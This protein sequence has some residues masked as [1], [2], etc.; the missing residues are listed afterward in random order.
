MIL[1][2]DLGNTRC[3]WRLRDSETCVMRG[4]L[5]ISQSFDELNV[6]LQHYNHKVARVWVA[7]VVGDAL[8]QAFT[9][10]SITFLSVAPEF[11]RSKESLGGLVNAYTEPGRLGV[12]RWL[13]MIACHHRV[14]GAFLLVSLG[15]AITIDI[16]LEN[17]QHAGGFIAPGVSLMLNSLAQGT[18]QVKP[19]LNE[20]SFNLSPGVSTN[21]AI[22]AALAAMLLGLIDNGLSQLRNRAPGAAFDIIFSGGDAHVLEQF[23]PQAHYVPELVLD[24]LAYVFQ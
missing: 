24:G 17:G 18:R 2:F 8:E 10:W 16:V 21:D 9:Q 6:A 13:G 7:S 12:D 19:S 1:E 20:M 23:Y 3:K 4:S 22:S 5:L 15:T 11:A 14:Q